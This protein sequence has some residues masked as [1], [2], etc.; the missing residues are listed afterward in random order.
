[1]RQKLKSIFRL[2][3]VGIS[4]F[5]LTLVSLIITILYRFAPYFGR[6]FFKPSPKHYGEIALNTIHLQALYATGDSWEKKYKILHSKIKSCRTYEETL[7]FISE[8]LKA[9]GGNHS[10]LMK[11]DMGKTSKM[12][13]EYPRIDTKDD[14][15]YINIPRFSGT[16]EECQKFKDI[17][18]SSLLNKSF[19]NVIIDLRENSG[20]NMGPMITGLTS[21]LND[22]HLIS[23][24]MKD[25]SEFKVNIEDGE[26]RN[27]GTPTTVKHRKFVRV[28]KIAVLISGR[29][30]S[31][32]EIIAISFDGVPN[33][34]IFGEKSAGFTTSNNTVTLYDGVMLNITTSKLKTRT[35]KI[36]ENNPIVPDVETSHPYEDAVEWFKTV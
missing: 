3:T 28:N 6:Y 1:M 8:A 13:M 27:A 24:V 25:H 17:I 35:G 29:T 16:P 7:P 15:L 26:I 14:Y 5:S 30:A 4:I 10:F 23:F 36:Y 18:E 2:K 31:S 9:G 32:G 21:L 19:E 34:K 12:P 22:G 11:P 20:G 33:T